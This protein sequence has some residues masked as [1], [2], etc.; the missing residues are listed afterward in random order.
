MPRLPEVQQFVSN[1]GVRIYRIACQ[2]MPDLSG[3]VHLVLGAGPPTLVDTGSGLGRSTRDILSG[4]DHVRTAFGEPAAIERVERILLTHAH[5]DH[6]GGLPELLEKSGARVGVHEL[7]ARVLTA[8]HERSVLGAKRL[9]RFLHEAGVA[10]ADQPDMV[11]RYMHIRP[12]PPRLPVDFLLEEG[13]DLDGMRPIHTPGHAAGHVCIQVGDVLL[14]GD[15]ILSK[16]IPQQWPEGLLLYTGLGHYLE[17]LAK[18]ERLE[19]VRLVLGGHEA[20]VEDVAGRIDEI[21]RLQFRRL[22]RVLEHLRRSGPL[23]LVEIARLMYPKAEGFHEVLAVQ[24]AGARVEYLQ[25]RGRVAVANL[26]EVEKE[27]K[28]V[29]RYV[30]A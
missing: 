9:G 27:E 3:R 14:A 22:D 28:P 4:I 2:V 13:A 21:R 7:D 16:T 18:V 25:L 30:P 17:S 12:D 29:M 11:R 5:V 24:D 1:T 26:A 19:G 6:V 10:P 15:H 8:Y 20:P 23:T